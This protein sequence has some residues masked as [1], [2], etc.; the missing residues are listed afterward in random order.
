MT[1][2]I[3]NPEYFSF[4]QLNKI[5]EAYEGNV[6]K[7][8]SKKPENE[9]T[10]RVQSDMVSLGK[11]DGLKDVM[12]L[13]GKN[14]MKSAKSVSADKMAKHLSGK[15][16]KVDEKLDVLKGV[17]AK[18]DEKSAKQLQDQGYVIYDNS[19][20][21]LL[22]DI[23]KITNVEV[24]SGNPW[25]MPKIEDVKWTGVE[26]LHD[27]GITGKGEV[28]AVIDSGYDHPGKE[29]IA[30]KDIPDGKSKPWD[31]NGH[32][33]HVAG[34]AM[35]MAPD[36]DLVAVRVMRSDGTGRPSDIVKGL[37]WVIE[38]KDQ[39]NIGVVNMSLGGA[40]DGYP[41]Y[42][43]PINK[44]VGAATKEGITV[45]AAAGNSGPKPHT[46][47]SPADS[48][49]ALSVGAALNPGK[50]SDFSS[51]GPT[52]DN[53]SK[54]DVV[55]PGEF[56][57]SWAV[58]GSQLNQI[59]TVVDT[60]RKMTPPQLR[61]LFT[62]KPEL[63]QALGLPKD[64]TKY[65][66]KKLEKTTKTNLPPMYKPTEDTLAGPGTSFASP[67]VAGIVAGLRQHSADDSP[68]ALKNSIKNTASNMGAQYSKM[69]QGSGFVQADK[70]MGKLPK[71]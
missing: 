39:Y 46:I 47:G 60:I 63:T 2:P 18:I 52:D 34:D 7:N 33:T 53:F 11:S 51:R 48:P 17:T 42:F 69:D 32:G 64:I 62:A 38:N 1:G 56:I 35:K 59:A 45:V 43:D 3:G 57:T 14:L 23:P 25:D 27:Q 5:V 30:W 12:I 31:P 28:I 24:K 58:P 15:G 40:P 67:E 13:P 61:K 54:P 9:N 10:V 26:K 29:L 55:A 66:D 44:A 21:N 68:D 8:V 6:T 20:R 71:D 65:D 50:V 70:A 19:P 22:P 36:A 16:I 41:Y 37:Q 49:Q 4:N